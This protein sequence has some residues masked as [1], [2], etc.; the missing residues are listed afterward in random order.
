MNF[1]GGVNY[2]HTPGI[3]NYISNI[4]NNYATSAG[5]FIG[6]NIS[7]N[8]D[9]SLGYNGSY[10]IVK[11]TTQK[12][13]D[14][15]YFSH[16]STFRINWIFWKGIVIN[17]DVTHT[18]YNGLSQGF[19]QQYLLWNAYIGYKF[20]K[21]KSLEAKISVF[22]ILNQNRSININVTG[23]YREESYTSVLR[24]YALFTLTYTIKHFKS[25][26]APTI[27]E[28]PNPFPGGRPPGM[29]RPD[30]GGGGGNN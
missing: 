1:N 12:Q 14:N 23:A 17:T 29:R 15:N 20:L 27:E 21:D 6:S 3:I 19:N 10:T 22:D 30:G 13:S 26:A 2:S 9:F 16:S 5:V 28:N 4:S 24:R 11:N 18:L 7:Q 8:L 25:G